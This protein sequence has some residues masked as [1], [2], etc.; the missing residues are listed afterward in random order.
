[1]LLLLLPLLQIRNSTR[2]IACSTFISH[3][4]F[5]A[6]ELW[7]HRFPMPAWRCS[8]LAF[9][10]LDL[11][12]QWK[13]EEWNAIIDSKRVVVINRNFCSFSSWIS[14]PIFPVPIFFSLQLHLF[15]PFPV[16]VLVL[17]PNCQN[18]L[19]T[20][21]ACSLSCM[22]SCYYY[23]KILGSS[24]Q[25]ASIWKLQNSESSIKNSKDMKMQKEK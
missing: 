15:V 8:V 24:I 4:A 12:V 5:T 1:M 17:A 9:V 20:A 16:L 2:N 22:T 10:R 11:F 25:P 14:F 21:C 3:C 6:F 18:A 19:L 7:V 23:T 13:S